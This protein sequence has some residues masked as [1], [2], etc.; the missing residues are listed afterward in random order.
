M[1]ESGEP[2]DRLPAELGAFL[3]ALVRWRPGLLLGD[4]ND[5]MWPGSVQNLARRL[6]GRAR[7]RT[8]PARMPLLKLDRIYCRPAQHS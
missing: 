2:E 7:Q 8:F 4:F 5:W 1:G 3:G 6:P